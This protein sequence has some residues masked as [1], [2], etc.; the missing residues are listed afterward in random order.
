MFA[1]DGA[2]VV[3]SVRRTYPPVVPWRYPGA[4]HQRRSTVRSAV[5]QKKPSL[6]RRQGAIA[7]RTIAGN[8][9]I[10]STRTLSCRRN[11]GSR[12]RRGLP[13]RSRADG[14]APA[15]GQPPPEWAANA[16]AWPA[17]NYDLANTRATTQT[18]INS[19]TVS[20]LKVKWT[21]R[22]SR[23]RARFGVFASTP[24][25]LNGTVYLQDLNSNVYAL[26]RTTGQVKWQHTFNKPSVGPNGVAF[27]YGRIYGATE[28]NAF[29]LDAQTGQH[30]LDPRS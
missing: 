11:S 13:P 6:S 18:P 20:K 1:T 25:V 30:A 7:A 29:A 8:N 2:F 19:Q 15:V 3:G 24:I 10:T 28:T 12:R 5:G 9:S 21:L 23:A 27:G 17:H 4:L 26:D 14:Q 22:R 16:G